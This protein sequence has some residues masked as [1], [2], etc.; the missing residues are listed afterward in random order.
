MLQ[1]LIESILNGVSVGGRMLRELF[2][3]FFDGIRFGIRSIFSAVNIAGSFIPKLFKS[4]L[5]SFKKPTSR[6]DYIETKGMFISKKLILIVVL[7]IAALVVVGLT[8]VRPFLVSKFGVAHMWETD[9]KTE[10]YNGKVILYYDEEKKM[11]K[12]EGRLEKGIKT[13]EGKEYDEEGKVLFSGN[14]AEGQRNGTGSVYKEGKLI[15]EGSVAGEH[16]EGEGT[17]Y[18]PDGNVQYRGGFHNSL[19]D[20]KG[21]LY[22]DTDTED[23]LY[24][25]DFKEGK[26]DGQGVLT[27]KGYSGKEE[28]HGGFSNGVYEGEGEL[29]Y[30]GISVYKGGFS[31]GLFNGT[32]RLCDKTGKEQYTGGFK[33][34][35][36]S[37]EGVYTAPNG[38]K[39]SGTFEKGGISGDAVC[40]Y[41]GD[42]FYKGNMNGLIPQGTGTLFSKSGS[43]LYTGEILLWNVNGSSL[44]GLSAADARKA[45]PQGLREDM[46]AEGFAL[47]QDKLGLSLYSGYATAEEEAAIKRVYLMPTAQDSTM[48]MIHWKTPAE[49]EEGLRALERN[50][51]CTRG[52][53]ICALPDV[54][55]SIEYISRNPMV[56]WRAYEQED[57]SVLIMWLRSTGT[58]DD[59][60]LLCEWRKAEDAVEFTGKEVDPNGN[61]PLSEAFGQNPDGTGE[62]VKP[63]KDNA[64]LSEFLMEDMTLAPTS[65]SNIK[66][67]LLKKQNEED[68]RTL[69]TDLV[70]YSLNSSGRVAAATNSEIYRGLA[71]ATAEQ[72]AVGKA[73]KDDASKLEEK[74]REYD[75]VLVEKELSLIEL[76]KKILSETG[77]NAEELDTQ[78]VFLVVNP[79]DLN[80]EELGKIILSQTRKASGVPFVSSGPGAAETEEDPALEPIM[81]ELSFEMRILN[82][83]YKNIEISRAELTKA[84]QQA[85]EAE[86]ARNTG[87]VTQ[88]ALAQAQVQLNDKQ[89]ALIADCAEFTKEMIILDRMTGGYISDK[90]QW[91]K[92]TMPEIPVAENQFGVEGGG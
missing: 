18:Y 44:L 34:G 30:D 27:D 91:F 85:E 79:E 32:G 82:A 22:N 86:A 64:S 35:L 5:E 57:G 55:Y 92:E 23:I 25:G 19:Y 37:G 1:N 59:S 87:S 31:Q 42:V 10:S 56:S 9:P 16:Y 15:Y 89:A 33:D 66:D 41:G 60:I 2:T 51:S 78:T 48:A 61:V 69:L 76:E 11:P 70:D 26:Y 71:E 14:Y 38:I 81:Q 17:L 29:F 21:T 88:E 36:F 75:A 47:T 65:D 43:E 46:G 7:V 4:I 6:E 28:Y 58:S 74:Q 50:A 62:P 39:I 80:P 73:E 63:G 8:V 68:K 3:R 54:Y 52:A 72:I 49:Y 20:G 40:S 77:K 13:G 53:G 67:E 83:L 45:F 84:K 12:F 90:Y 24:K